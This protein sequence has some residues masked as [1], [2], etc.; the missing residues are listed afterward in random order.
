MPEFGNVK[1]SAALEQKKLHRSVSDLGDFL[2]LSHC[3]IYRC[4]W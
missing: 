4:L 1:Y 2:Q 3:V